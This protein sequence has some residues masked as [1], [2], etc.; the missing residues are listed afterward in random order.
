[1]IGTSHAAPW[2]SGNASVHLTFSRPAQS[3]S[4]LAFGMRT[5]SIP[6]LAGVAVISA[7]ETVRYWSLSSSGLQPSGK[8]TRGAT[9]PAAIG[10]TW[11]LPSLPAFVS[12]LSSPGTGSTAP[13]FISDTWAGVGGSSLP[14]KRDALL[15]NSMVA[16][17]APLPFAL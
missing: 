13:E 7:A 3:F 11:A 2:R 6:F 16:T 4:N 14:A 1:M 12:A 10:K 17:P 9:A 5:R 15:R 8:L